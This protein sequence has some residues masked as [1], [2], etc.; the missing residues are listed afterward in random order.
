MSNWVR[1]SK[2]LNNYPSSMLWLLLSRST[3]WKLNRYVLTDVT[4]SSSLRMFCVI[5]QCAM[6]IQLNLMSHL[7]S[8]GNKWTMSRVKKW[9]LRK[10]GRELLWTSRP[11]TARRPIGTEITS[12]LRS[13]SVQSVYWV[14]IQADATSI[15]NLSILFIAYSWCS[16]FWNAMNSPHVWNWFN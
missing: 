5:G 12:E 4:C 8:L 6:S 15:N 10:S 1:S 14:I 9:T 13:M 7:M 3:R 11:G 16:K 2:R